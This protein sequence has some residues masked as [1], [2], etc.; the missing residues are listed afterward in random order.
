M[1]FSIRKLILFL[2]INN[3]VFSKLIFNTL[4]QQIVFTNTI[5]R[6]DERVATIFARHL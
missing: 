4:Q 6:R 3:I 1:Y 5:M 2:L